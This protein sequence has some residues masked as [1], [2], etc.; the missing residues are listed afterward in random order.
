MR[1][2]QKIILASSPLASRIFGIPAQP[3]NTS[4]ARSGGVPG[5][6]VVLHLSTRLL[7]GLFGIV[8]GAWVAHGR[9][10]E[11]QP[12]RNL[13]WR[14]GDSSY[15]PCCKGMHCNGRGLDGICQLPSSTS[16]NLTK[17]RRVPASYFP[18][19]TGPAPTPL[20]KEVLNLSSSFPTCL[21]WGFRA[22]RHR[23]Q[24]QF[25]VQEPVG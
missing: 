12:F 2:G 8:V 4:D 11:L 15:T 22:F 13:L 21:R 9:L 19:V 23:P 25:H 7:L 14:K 16:Q 3:K 17:A 18:L 20:P 24:L 10:E 6:P 5:V 1:P